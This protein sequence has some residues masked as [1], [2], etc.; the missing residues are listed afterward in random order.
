MILFI[1]KRNYLVKMCPIFDS[2]HQSCVTRYQEILWGCSFWCKN[3]L[4]F[5][6]NTRKFHNRCYASRYVCSYM[7]PLEWMEII[8][9]PFCCLEINLMSQNYRSLR[10]NL[11]LL[12]LAKIYPRCSNVDYSLQR[13]V[14]F[15]NPS[16]HHLHVS[17]THLTLQ[18]KRIV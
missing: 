2:S 13:L 14:L 7:W 16:D 17:Y 15:S 11:T 1:P 5:T 12:P 8:T 4:N 3:L 10:I 6:W 18:T 9:S